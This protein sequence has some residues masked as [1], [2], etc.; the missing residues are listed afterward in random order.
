MLQNTYFQSLHKI[1][2]FE[3]ISKI[4]F[5]H[6]KERP[7]VPLWILNLGFGD[8]HYICMTTSIATQCIVM[9]YHYLSFQVGYD[10][11]LKKKLKSKNLISKY[12]SSIWTHLQANFCHTSLGSKVLV[13]QFGSIK[14]FPGKTIRKSSGPYGLKGMEYT[15]EKN[16]GSADL[17]LYVAV[18]QGCKTVCKAKM[19]TYF[20][21]QITLRIVCYHLPSRLTATLNIWSIYFKL[22]LHVL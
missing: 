19:I 11:G 18:D 13:Q 2:N 3:Q 7:K 1:F 10:D 17:M 15:T 6:V 14:H 8:F 9:M 12:I 16:L 22:F 20:K 4:I 21:R 5:P